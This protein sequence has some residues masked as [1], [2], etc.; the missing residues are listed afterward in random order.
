MTSCQPDILKRF[1]ERIKKLEKSL[2]LLKNGGNCAE[3][4]LTN[5]M[6]ILGIDNFF[7]HNLAIP[8]AGGFGGYKSKT[9]WMGA[10]GAVSGGIAALGIVLGGQEKLSS[11]MATIATV[12]AR[13]FCDDADCSRN[14]ARHRTRRPH[15]QHW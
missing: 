10:C 8:F 15:S 9:G 1:D 6:E 7:F 2:P 5:V 3:L 4:T 11:E 13:K 12:K 14:R